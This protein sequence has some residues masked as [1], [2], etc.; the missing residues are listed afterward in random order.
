M[1]NSASASS[2]NFL[3]SS[4]NGGLLDYLFVN[5]SRLRRLAHLNF[6]G[7]SDE[8]F[9]SLGLLQCLSLT[10]RFARS[11]DLLAFDALGFALGFVILKAFFKFFE[12]ILT[13]RLAFLFL[14]VVGAGA[15][16]RLSRRHNGS[17]LATSES[18]IGRE[19]AQHGKENL[20]FHLHASKAADLTPLSKARFVKI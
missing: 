2:N 6:L 15:F 10:L 4:S 17:A 14:L 7:I 18:R 13:L 5:R 9:G 11:L 16:D 12:T 3:S 19:H 20:W 1:K 8:I